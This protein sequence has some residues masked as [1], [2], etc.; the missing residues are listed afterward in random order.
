[1]AMV[2]AVAALLPATTSAATAYVV[3]DD[4]GWDTGVD[5]SAWLEGKE[6]V[7]G[8]TLGMYVFFIAGGAHG[9]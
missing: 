5:Y 6:F 7:V 8:D 2:A 9:G 3:G 1:M 4:D